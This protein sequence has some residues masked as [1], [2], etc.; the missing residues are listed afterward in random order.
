MEIYN[1]INKQ[2]NIRLLDFEIL[3]YKKYELY[4]NEGSKFL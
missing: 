2:M 3:K 4:K 1:R